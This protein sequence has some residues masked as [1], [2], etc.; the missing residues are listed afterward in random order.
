MSE[1]QLLYVTNEITR[2]KGLIQQELSFFIL[3]EN[4]S[5]NKKIDVVWAGEDGVWQALPAM[6]HSSPVQ[7]KE[8]W[9]LKATFH[10]ASDKALPGNIQFALRYRVAGG[11]YWDNNRGLNYR[12]QANSGI[13]IAN[14]HPLLNIGFDQLLENG[15]KLVPITVA[16]DQSLRAKKVT[17][18]WTTDD[19]KHTHITRCYLKRSRSLNR[20]GNPIQDGVHVWRGLLNIGHAFR[21]QYSICCESADQLV[22]DNNFG[23]NYSARRKPLTVMILNLHCMQEENQDYKFSQIAKAINE[24]DVDIA[25]LQEVAEPWNDGKGDWELNSAKIINERLESPYHLYADWSHLGF[26]QYREGVA[27]LSRYPIAKHESRYVSES[28]D[29]YDI[30]SRKVVM[31]Q[32]NV[33]C[34]GAINVFSAHVSWWDDGFHEQFEN[35]RKWAAAKHT[36]HIKGTLLCGDFNIKA[37]SRGYELVVNSNE[38][39]DQFLAANNPDAFERIFGERRPNWQRNLLDDYRIDYIF[40]NKSSALRVTSGRVLFTAHDYGTVSDH[41]GYLMTFEPL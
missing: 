35:L 20:D 10:P 29:P 17:I 12:S 9:Q 3:V 41:S 1:I 5:C 8:Y 23:K 33:P 13:Q 38:Y 30:H 18:H 36:S 15:R 40:M 14:T 11:E 4:L 7:D 39:E 31:T 24:L 16:V 26:D 27:V 2:K 22:W 32:V 6:Y 37:G 28:D 34:V 25:C 21:L 19:W